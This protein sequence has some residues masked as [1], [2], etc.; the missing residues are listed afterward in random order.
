[1]APSSVSFLSAFL[2]VAT[3]LAGCSGDGGKAADP[4][5]GADF[6]DLDFEATATTG[7]IRGVVVDDAIRPLANA[8]VALLGG[9][10]RET[11][12]NDAGAFGFDGLP[13]GTYF[14]QVG[15]LGYFEVQQS[16]EV[17]AGVTEPDAIKVQLIRDP[18]FRAFYEAHV[19]EGFVECTTSV[20]VACGAPNTLEPLSCEFFGVCYGNVT[21]DRFTWDQYLTPNAT[22]I[23]S[24]MVWS[25]TQAVS[26]DLSFEMEALGGDCDPPNSSFLNDTSGPSPI[27]TRLHTDL[28][29]E[30]EI[31]QKCPIFYSIFSGGAAG[32]P[33]GVTVEQRFTM[34]IHA[35]YGYLPPVD[36]RF[37]TD[38][39]VTPP[40]Q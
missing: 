40:P 35:F 32:T 7:I 16:A 9:L 21:N 20:V 5:V 36:W 17:V 4:I 22:M 38:N 23:Q 27:M 24:E 1:M 18:Q 12:S 25:S 10:A 11:R 29:T 30:N 26:P 3:L 13:G 8:T 33:V 15:K 28:I 6:D 31:G 37:S 34:Y 19:Y 39:A 2:V 14:L